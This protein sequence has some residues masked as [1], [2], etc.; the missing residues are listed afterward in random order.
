MI[1]L[2][3]INYATIDRYMQPFMQTTRNNEKPRF[4]SSSSGRSIAGDGERLREDFSSGAARIETP[5]KVGRNK[6]RISSRWLMQIRRRCIGQMLK[7]GRLKIC[8]SVPSAI[9]ETRPHNTRNKPLPRCF[10]G[11]P[12][13]SLVPSF[14]SFSSETL[15]LRSHTFLPS[16]IFFLH[17]RIFLILSLAWFTRAE[18]TDGDTFNLGLPL[19]AAISRRRIF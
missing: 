12:F 13:S 17:L 16:N 6:F 19:G 9:G 5:T 7:N 2:I 18:E 1:K 8:G 15:F 3:N 14:H 4:R 10:N 11:T